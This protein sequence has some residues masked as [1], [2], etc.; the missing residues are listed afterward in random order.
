MLFSS[1]EK[2]KRSL[3]RKSRELGIVLHKKYENV[4]YIACRLLLNASSISGK[5]IK[6]RSNLKCYSLKL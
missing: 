1:I 5:L 4:I 3:N 6:K 2:H